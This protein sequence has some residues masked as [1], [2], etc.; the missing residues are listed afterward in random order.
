MSKQCSYVHKRERETEI[1][2]GNLYDWDYLLDEVLENNFNFTWLNRQ[3]TNRRKTRHCWV[4]GKC[5]FTTTG[6][7]IIVLKNHYD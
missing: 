4:P 3:K 2:R 1:Y 6:Q 7:E 5:F